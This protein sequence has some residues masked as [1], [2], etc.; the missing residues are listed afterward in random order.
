LKHEFGIEKSFQTNCPGCGGAFSLTIPF[1]R[2]ATYQ[3]PV[4]MG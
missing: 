1:R 4:I 3:L 2:K